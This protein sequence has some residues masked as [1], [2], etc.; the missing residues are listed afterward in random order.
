MKTVKYYYVTI[1]MQERVGFRGPHVP[2]LAG[3]DQK[4]VMEAAKELAATVELPPY[5]VER[6]MRFHT[7]VVEGSGMQML[8]S[9]HAHMTER[10]SFVGD[11]EEEAGIDDWENE[12]LTKILDNV[13]KRRF[14]E[15]EMTCD[16]CCS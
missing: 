6:Y 12:G 14:K 16:H 15:K 8:P 4:A 2:V 7:M 11:P 9:L 3:L 13:F 5:Q 10:C 1:D